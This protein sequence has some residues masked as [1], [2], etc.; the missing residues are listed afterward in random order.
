[1]KMKSCCYSFDDLHRAAVGRPMN[2]EERTRLY[3]LPQAARNEW[4]RRRVEQSR[5]AFA[6]EERRGTDGVTYTAFWA[7]D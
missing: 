1:M 6:C 7:C 3:G 4:V 2:D 5:G